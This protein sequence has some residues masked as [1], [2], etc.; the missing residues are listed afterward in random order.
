MHIHRHFYLSSMLGVW[1]KWEDVDEVLK[2]SWKT[3]PSVLEPAVV[4][5]SQPWRMHYLPILHISFSQLSTSHF[6]KPLPHHNLF[7]WSWNH[8]ISRVWKELIRIIES[9]LDGQETGMT[10]GAPSG[11]RDIFM[12]PFGRVIE[13][14]S[15]GIPNSVCTTADPS[16]HADAEKSIRRLF[17]APP[18]QWA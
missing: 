4:F 8:R 1:V 5:F 7:Q 17:P 3:H 13:K 14:H 18:I 12:V 15:W 11:Q 9:N 6:S 10:L 16:G 2:S